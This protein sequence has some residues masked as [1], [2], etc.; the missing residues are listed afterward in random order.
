[1]IVHRWSPHILLMQ[2]WTLH[3]SSPPLCD[4][5]IAQSIQVSD[6]PGPAKK[7]FAQTDGQ[8]LGKY[9]QLITEFRESLPKCEACKY[10]K[11]PP[12]G[13][14]LK[15][16]GCWQ[17][18]IQGQ[19]S[20]KVIPIS[21]EFGMLF[22]LGRSHPDQKLRLWRCRW[23][24]S[25]LQFQDDASRQHAWPFLTQIMIS[26]TVDYHIWYQYISQLPSWNKGTPVRRIWSITFAECAWV[27]PPPFAGK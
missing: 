9:S 23:L 15:I 11:Y 7:G 25:G 3:W 20:V 10:H 5:V 19:G 13:L 6:R 21:L 8:L 26:L 27:C 12:W 24:D 1:M 16:Q 2:A 14:T 22:C 18:S 4:S 17:A